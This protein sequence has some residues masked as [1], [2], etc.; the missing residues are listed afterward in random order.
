MQRLE[1]IGDALTTYR[2]TPGSMQ[3]CSKMMRVHLDALGN[4]EAIVRLEDAEAKSS[5]AREKK[6]DWDQEKRADPM[7]RTDSRKWDA[8][9]DTSLSGLASAPEPYTTLD[10]DSEVKRLAT[11]FINELFP[12]GVRPIT[13]QRY[14]DQHA[15]VNELLQRVDNDFTEHVDKLGLGPLVDQLERFNQRYGESLADEDEGV[16]YSDVKAATA[17][18]QDAFHKLLIKVIHDYMDDVETLNRVLKPFFQQEERL[19]RHYQRSGGPPSVDP[20]TG[21]MTDGEE[22]LD[23]DEEPADVEADEDVVVGSN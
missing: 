8:R 19:R 7:Q 17:A 9:V 14:E 4:D 16:T 13:S 21:E 18:A 6:Y 10:G 12:A 2:H 15:A 23:S 5:E 3:Y 11:E 1:E 22:A 20:D